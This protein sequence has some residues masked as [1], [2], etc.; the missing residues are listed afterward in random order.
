MQNNC[1]QITKGKRDSVEVFVKWISERMGRPPSEY[2]RT[3]PKAANTKT[4]T[5]TTKATSKSPPSPESGSQKIQ[6][7]G[8]LPS[9]LPPYAVLRKLESE[10]NGDFSTAVRS[11]ISVIAFTENTKFHFIATN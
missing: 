6:T 7:P 9:K 3:E 5:E 4:T 1:F 10:K 8:K 2:K 11:Q